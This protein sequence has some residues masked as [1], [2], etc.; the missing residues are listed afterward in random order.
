MRAL[1]DEIAACGL[2]CHECSIFKAHSDKE[3]AEKVRDWFLEEGFL[4]EKKSIEEFMADGPYCSGC[5]GN[6][7]NHW[8]PECWILRC[9]VDEKGL[10][11]CSE[12]SD[13]PCTGLE[14]WSTQDES[15]NEALERMKEIETDS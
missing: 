8:S 4:D 7:D 6:R 9:C 14:E 11:N 5:H 10:N 15:Y 1:E 13:F 3:Q 12:C 2:L